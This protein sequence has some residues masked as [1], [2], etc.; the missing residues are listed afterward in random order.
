MNQ[1]NNMIALIA[2]EGI[3]SNLVYNS[4]KQFWPDNLVVIIEE[5]IEKIS[6]VKSKI[7][8][9]GLFDFFGQFLFLTLIVPALKAI[10]KKRICEILNKNNFS[11]ESIPQHKTTKVNSVNSEECRQLLRKLNPDLIIVNGTRIIS[12]KTLE[13]VSCKWINTHTG[14]T[15]EFR[16]VHGAYWALYINRKEL[17]GYTIHL[18][19]KGVDTGNI[20]KQGTIETTVNDNYATYP[21]LQYI[22]AIPDLIEVIKEILANQ[23]TEKKISKNEFSKQWFHPTLFQYLFGL[24]FK[25]IK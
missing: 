20:L 25:G 2:T 19:D 24:I 14:I 23:L 10:S 15:S 18:I 7:K 11:A 17:C 5:P 8:R 4:L 13:C 16:G 6:L 22:A 12:T 21:L 1:G 3:T 9:N